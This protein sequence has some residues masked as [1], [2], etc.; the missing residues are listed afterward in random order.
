[1]YKFLFLLVAL[2]PKVNKALFDAFG[3]ALMPPKI[4]GRE[5]TVLP[6]LM[7][8]HTILFDDPTILIAIKYLPRVIITQKASPHINL[9]AER[10]NKFHNR[11]NENNTR[12]TMNKVKTAAMLYLMPAFGN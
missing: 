3:Q 9:S 5:L 11:V 8:R 1:M 2:K 4:N 7:I 6:L 12:C 10:T